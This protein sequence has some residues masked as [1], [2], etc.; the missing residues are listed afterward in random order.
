MRWPWVTYGTV[1][2]LMLEAVK[3]VHQSWREDRA[4]MQA[5]YD[6]LLDKYHS[7]RLQGAAQPEPKTTLERPEFDP[8]QAAIT[9]KAGPDRKLRALMGR[10][11]ADA[12]RLGISDH[13][14]IR[15]IEQGVEI[16]DGIPA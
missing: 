8:V 10:E 12:R 15:Q 3:G 1:H 13:E 4:D 11:A 14:I 6:D 7:L 2:Q 16:D 5:R 9:A